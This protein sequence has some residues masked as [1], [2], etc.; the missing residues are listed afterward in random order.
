MH[1]ELVWRS[2]LF[3]PVNIPRFVAKAPAIGA[4]AILL[5][6]EDSIA[7]SEKES[8]RRDILPAAAMLAEAGQCVGVRINRPMSLAV[9]DIE[10]AIA[11]GV[12]F[13]AIPKVMSTDHLKLLDEVISERELVG[14]MPVGSTRLIAMIED[15]EGYRNMHDIA[16]GQS[17]LAAMSL[18]TEDFAAALEIEPS[19]E[20]LTMPKQALVIAARAGAVLPLGIV[21]PTTNLSDMVAFQQA[22]EMSARFGF[23]GSYAVHPGQV[24]ILNQA[25]TPKPEAIDKARAV[26]KA[27]EDAK[28]SGAGAV[29]LNGRMIDKPVVERA[30]RL[31]ARAEMIAMRR[32]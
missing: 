29:Q 4:D 9:R 32:S 10:A 28:V 26:I 23:T 31:L 5:D 1:R 17:R 14:G 12:S 27:L 16:V 25:F 22:A 18:G 11:P 20:T 24:A 15:P 6:L 3:V 13:L 2:I 8:A 7:P 19:I 30:E 21:G